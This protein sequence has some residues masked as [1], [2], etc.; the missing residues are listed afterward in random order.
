M[1]HERREPALRSRGS[2]VKSSRQT[3]WKMSA[4]SSR[5]ARYLIGIE[6]IS[7]LYFSRI[8][9]QASSLPARRSRTS[10][11]SVQEG[12]GVFAGFLGRARTRSTARTARAEPAKVAD[13]K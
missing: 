11:A 7:L 8:A 13:L 1:S 9:D 2:S 10:L 6:K 12:F 3:A 4:A 5:L